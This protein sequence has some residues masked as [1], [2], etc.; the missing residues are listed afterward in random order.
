LLQVDTSFALIEDLNNY[1]IL[2]LTFPVEVSENKPEPD[3]FVSTANLREG[4]KQSLEERNC[5]HEDAEVE[6]PK[7]RVPTYAL[8]VEDGLSKEEEKRRKKAARSF[9]FRERKKD[10]NKK[11]LEENKILKARIAELE[12]QVESLSKQS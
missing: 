7:K 6:Q 8:P 10:E 5:K 4:R 11:L 2:G 3:V 12:A 1:E 9:A